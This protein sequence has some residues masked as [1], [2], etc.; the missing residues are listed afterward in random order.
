MTISAQRDVRVML[1]SRVWAYATA[2]LLISVLLTGQGQDQKLLFLPATIVFGAVISTIVVLRKLRYDQHNTLF[3][4]ETLEEL[5][6]RIENLEAIA[7]TDD[8]HWERPLNQLA[9]TRSGLTEH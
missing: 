6:R 4:S 5:K 1:I 3:Q 2:M 8:R 7:A 9:Q